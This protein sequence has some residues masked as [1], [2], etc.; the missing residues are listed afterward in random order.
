VS[1]SAG[2]ACRSVP[3]A[4]R[5]AAHVRPRG[6]VGGG[7]CRCVG[8][9]HTGEPGGVVG[10]RQVG[11]RW[12]VQGRGGEDSAHRRPAGGHIV[13]TFAHAAARRLGGSGGAGATI[14]GSAQRGSTAPLTPSRGFERLLGQMRPGASPLTRQQSTATTRPSASTCKSFSTTS[15]SPQRPHRQ[16]FFDERRQ[17]PRW[18]PPYL[19]KQIGNRRAPGLPSITSRPPAP[20]P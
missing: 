14:D 11:T 2:S 19:E 9:S 13:L 20:D 7:W 8:G 3:D 17:A 10:W 16:R 18:K 5:T 1:G 12:C 6:G 15:P 4:G